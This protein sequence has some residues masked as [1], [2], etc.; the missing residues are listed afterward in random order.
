MKLHQKELKKRLIKKTMDFYPI[1]RYPSK[2][3][4]GFALKFERRLVFLL[5][6]IGHFIKTFIYFAFRNI[7]FYKKWWFTNHSW[8]FWL[9][10]SKVAFEDICEINIYR[11]LVIESWW[12]YPAIISNSY[13]DVQYT[14]NDWTEHYLFSNSKR[15]HIDKFLNLFQWLYTIKVNDFSDI[16]IDTRKG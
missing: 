13:Y 16:Q 9:N 1:T 14:L 11:R 3:K 12:Y 2:N 6:D 15:E 5:F 7:T 4:A 8:I 10:T